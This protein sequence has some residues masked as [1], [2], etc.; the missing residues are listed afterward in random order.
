MIILGITDH[1]TSGA[2][3][4]VDGRVTAAVNEERLVRSK[5]VMGFPWRSIETV[6]QVAGVRP[7]E[8]DCVA[9]ASRW[10]TFLPEYVD[11]SKGVFGVEEG[12]VKSLF[13]ALGSRLSFLRSKVPFLEPLYYRLRQPVFSYRRRAIQQ[14]LDDKYGIRCPVEYVWHHRAHA[15][16]AYYASGFDDA[17]VVTLDGSGDGHSSHVYDVANGRLNRLHAVR[18]FDG[19]GN[20]Y[21]YVTHLCGFTAGKHEGKV[22]GLSAYG[23]DTYREILERF[24]NYQAGTM[25]NVGNAFRW[26]AIEKLHR[27]LPKGFSREDLAASIQSVSE[28]ICTQ[29]VHHWRERT[30]RRNVAL[31]GGVFANVKINQRIHQLP[32][33]ENTFVYPAMSDEG[34]A[35]GAALSVSA[36]KGHSLHGRCFDHV[37]LGPE[38]SEQEIA[39]ALQRAGIE[40]SRSSGVEN[41]VA[42]LIADGYVVARFHGRMEFGPRALGN[43]SI[44]YRPDDPSVNDW[45]NQ[46]LRRTEFMPFAPATML[47]DADQCYAG[48]D[49]ARDTA[50]F[51]T[52]TADCTDTMKQSCPGVV[53][54]DGTARPQLVSNEDNPAYYRIIK[55]FKR[56]TGLTSIVNT[57]F[58]IHEEPIVCTPEDAIR[59]FNIGHLDVLAIGPFL[60]QSAAMRETSR[61]V[62]AH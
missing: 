33:V 59:A 32:G 60:A 16:C 57:S 40:F 26:A 24:I 9:V 2:A 20:Y 54:V 28:R 56:L 27:A 55:E 31:A 39:T 22:T 25:V 38:F 35:S 23:K 45:L 48:L 3:L 34:L 1:F 29:Y 58:N 46:R 30:G 4:V 37:Y 13:F 18:S 41:D 19:I 42:R 6:L 50:R 47:E 49:G 21:E 15:A 14:A 62:R 36:D 44:L 53:H 11:F 51:M 5:M 8:I 10:G 17:L 43:R 12:R 52:I 7:E 61:V